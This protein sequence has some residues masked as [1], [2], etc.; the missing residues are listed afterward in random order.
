MS[1]TRAEIYA[2]KMKKAGD[3]LLNDGSVFDPMK[4]LAIYTGMPESDQKR[5]S[6][7]PERAQKILQP[8]NV[9]R[10]AKPKQIKKREHVTD[11]DIKRILKLP[12]DA[13]LPKTFSEADQCETHDLVEMLSAIYSTKDELRSDILRNVCLPVHVDVALRVLEFRRVDVWTGAPLRLKQV[14]DS[15]SMQG[16]LARFKRGEF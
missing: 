3:K 11:E 7:V 13:P 10:P 14:R 15:E 2:E 4:G 6:Q 5:Q 12:P 16:K 8:E 9:G 1:K